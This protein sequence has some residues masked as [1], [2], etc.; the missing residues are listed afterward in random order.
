MSLLEYHVYNYVKQPPLQQKTLN[1]EEDNTHNYWFC[2]VLYCLSQMHTM[3]RTQFLEMIVDS[4]F[5]F[6]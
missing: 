5:I 1:S 6:A 4:D 2:S 3:I